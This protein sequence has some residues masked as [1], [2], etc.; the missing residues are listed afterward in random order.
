MEEVVKKADAIADRVHDV[1]RDAWDIIVIGAG[2]AGSLAAVHAARAGLRTLLIDAKHFPREKVCGGY[3]NRRALESLRQSGATEFLPTNFGNEVVELDLISGHQHAR[4][5]L[6]LG[7]VI[8]RTD[9]DA[10]LVEAA[11]AAGAD[12]FTGVQATVE[13]Q[14][15]EGSREV[16]LAHAGARSSTHA[17]VVICAD[18]LARMSVRRLPEFATAASPTS[19]VGIGAVVADSS[20]L[21]GD[22]RL[23]MV[24]ARHGYAGISRI[25]AYQ[26]NIAAAV[27]SSL[28]SDASPLEIIQSIFASANFTPSAGLDVATWR[29]TPALTIRPRKVA[30]ERVFL[31]GDAAGYVEPFTGEGMAAAF[32]SAAAVTPFVVE[33]ARAWSPRLA[34][35]WQTIH[36][37]TVRNRQRTCQTLAWILRRPWATFATLSTCR[38]LPA[39]ATRWISK[40]TAPSV[41]NRKES[42]TAL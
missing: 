34:S 24:V 13:P 4:F 26:L 2:P 23:N 6:P 3:L 17:R 42:I 10:C 35:A 16:T 7:S 33:A 37:E 14:S 15:H 25:N 31:I 30:S 38:A 12:V 32:E 20:R 8:C 40:T 36:R 18:G 29:G 11:K 21:C 1:T 5:P 27:E 22:G 41:P 39:V 9:F 19:R 28:L